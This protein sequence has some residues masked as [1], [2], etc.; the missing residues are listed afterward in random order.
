MKEKSGNVDEDICHKKFQ[1]IM[2]KLGKMLFSMTADELASKL[3][4]EQ[5]EE[6]MAG[7]PEADVVQAEV[8]FVE[9]EALMSRT[10]S[11]K[12]AVWQIFD[13][14]ETVVDEQNA[15]AREREKNLQNPC[16]LLKSQTISPIQHC[17]EILMRKDLPVLNHCGIHGAHLWA[18][19]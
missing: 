10:N 4:H 1:L 8:P 14:I 3:L 16:F 7:I 6:K 19:V 12:K 18:R 9:R 5:T 17:Q 13:C 11:L 2:E 15:E